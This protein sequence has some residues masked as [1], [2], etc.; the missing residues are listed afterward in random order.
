LLVATRSHPA[1]TVIPAKE[2]IR[3]RLP[4]AF[5]R[6]SGWFQLYAEMTAGAM[7]EERPRPLLTAE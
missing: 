1:L 2:P 3:L 5:R 4:D 6:R 7:H